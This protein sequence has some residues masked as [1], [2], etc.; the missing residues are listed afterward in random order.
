[1]KEKKEKRKK[2]RG[3]LILLLPIIIAIILSVFYGI[4]R[5]SAATQKGEKKIFTSSSLIE[6]IDIGEIS[7]AQ[8]TYNGIA[9]IHKDND[10][11]KKVE[12]YVKY[13]ATVKVGIDGDK[14]D[15]EIDEENKT[16]K[17]ILPELRITVVDLDDEKGFSYIP[18]KSHVG[19]KRA[20]EACEQDVTKEAQKSK[21]LFEV[22]ED[23]LKSHMEGLLQ[24][25]VE[26]YN[27]KI[28]WDE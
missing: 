15:F 7:T 27:Y 4:V 13:D 1:M 22:A 2:I 20:I 21:K 28:I 8:F 26:T 18:D 17:P 6:A 16:I 3:K 10:Q 11:N 23:N 19:L 12:S 5:Y 9:E 14:L 24:P 25:L